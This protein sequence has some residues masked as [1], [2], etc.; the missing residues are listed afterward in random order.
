MQTRFQAITTIL[1]TLYLATVL[2]TDISLTGFWTDV[3]FSI[4]LCIF[5][6]VFVF[7]KRTTVLWLTLTLRIL[8][9]SCSIIVFVLL[10]LNF[11]NPLSNDQKP[12]QMITHGLTMS[13]SIPG[14][15]SPGQLFFTEPL[16][17][18]TTFHLQLSSLRL[19]ALDYK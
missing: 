13:G 8:A 15:I 10:A 4:A 6:L 16:K 19:Q 2:L 3:I 9:L 14:L 1:L 12:S 11:A 5:N 17:T 7:R 18:K